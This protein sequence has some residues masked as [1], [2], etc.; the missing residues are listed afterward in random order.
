LADVLRKENVSVFT[1]AES[2]VTGA[3]WHAELLAQIKRCSLF[4]ALVDDLGQNVMFELGYAL[5]AAKQ[6][7]LMADPDTPIPFDIA[8]LPVARF[9]NYELSAVY[10]VAEKLLSKLG[11]SERSSLDLIE[12]KQAL[13]YLANNPDYVEQLSPREF[14]VFVAKLFNELGFETNQTPAQSD[15]GYDLVLWDKDQ[16]TKTIVE[17][18]KYARS[19]KLGVASVHQ[20]LGNMM[21]SDASSALLVTS[22]G[23]SASA[24]DMAKKSPRSIKL[25]TLEELIS[26]S[27]SQLQSSLATPDA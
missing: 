4:V 23:F 27:R 2:L 21:L 7:L 26:M 24:V 13:R 10:D 6:V 25:L 8:S 3:E 22:G 5:G 18:K 16:Q 12:G 14:E 1:E 15:V 9:D 20:L 17:I 11:D 19:S